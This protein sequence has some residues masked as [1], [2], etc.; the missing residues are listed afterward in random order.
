MVIQDLIDKLKDNDRGCETKCLDISQL[1]FD[2]ADGEARLYND[3]H[4]YYFKKDT[5]NPRSPKVVHAAK[6]FCKMIGVPYSFF[7]KNPEHMKNKMIDCWMPSLGRDSSMVLAR[8]R[9]VGSETVFRALLPMEHCNI[10]NVDI[11]GQ[12]VGVVGGFNID[13][14]TGDERDDL[15]LYVRFVAED[16]FNVFGDE[17]AYGFSIM[18]SD[19]GACPLCLNTLLYSKK[20]RTS[21]VASYGGGTG[22]FFKC[23]YTNIQPDDLKGLF[24]NL[25]ERLQGQLPELRNKIQHAQ[26]ITSSTVDFSVKAR[27]L[28]M[29]KGLPERFHILLYQELGDA[30]IGSLWEFANKVSAV[31]KR[32]DILK[33]MKIESMA[34]DLI[35]LGFEK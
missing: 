12:L 26:E 14:V 29:R 5:V 27:E 32:F 25:I 19:L 3:Y 24:P 21:M 15:M 6:Q 13:F 35:G 28:R 23:D 1:H 34:G 7:D 31:A 11:I 10:T 22:D 18:A 20:S 16:S 17:C 33:R 8:L 4:S 2:A 30:K 9:T